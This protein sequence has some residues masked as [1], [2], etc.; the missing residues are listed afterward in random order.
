MCLGLPDNAAIIRSRDAFER[1]AAEKEK[2]EAVVRY[3]C[4]SDADGISE[5]V[6]ARRSWGGCS[7]SHKR[8]RLAG[9]DGCSCHTGSHGTI[10]E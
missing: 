7:A 2:A 5:G 6:C 3:V 9:H 1:R 10:N 4:H 8:S